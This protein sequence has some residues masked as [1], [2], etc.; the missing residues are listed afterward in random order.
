MTLDYVT[1]NILHTY[2]ISSKNK[3]VMKT[4]LTKFIAVAFAAAGTSQAAVLLAYEFNADGN[5]LGFTDQNERF[6]ETVAGGFYTAV[7]GPSGSTDYQMRNNLGNGDA[8]TTPTAGDFTI[9]T[10]AGQANFITF[11]IR[12]D[13]GVADTPQ[14]FVVAADGGAGTGIAG[15]PITFAVPTI[16]QFQ[17]YTVNLATTLTPGNTFSSIRFD[18]R[19]TV[20]GFTVDYIRIESIPEPSSALLGFLGLGAICVRRRR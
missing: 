10:S 19:S 20:G 14:L 13:G 12:Q 15:S 1:K 5:T 11:R 18:P 9:G 8:G 3:V 2:T 4:T 16:D 6:T 7:D 17:T